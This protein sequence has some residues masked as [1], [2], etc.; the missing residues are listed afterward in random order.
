M[1][2]AFLFSIIFPRTSLAEMMFE[3]Y[4]M[5]GNLAIFWL[6][7]GKP[8]NWGR[9]LLRVGDNEGVQDNIV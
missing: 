3:M 1:F 7:G 8:Y 5:G 2:N 9:G 4:A 6:G